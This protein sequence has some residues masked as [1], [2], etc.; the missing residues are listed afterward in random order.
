MIRRTLVATAV[1]VMGLLGSSLCFAKL[2]FVTFD[3]LLKESSLIVVAHSTEAR[4]E[5]GGGGHALLKIGRVVRGSSTSPTI[6]IEWPGREDDQAI[7]QVDRDYLLFLRKDGNRYAPAIHGVSYWSLSY[8]RD[9]KQVVE[10]SYPTAYVT[11]PEEMIFTVEL[12]PAWR[13]ELTSGCVVKAI[14]VEGLLKTIR[15]KRDGTG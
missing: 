5:A 4:L 13:P 2:D 7:R 14:S 15:A 8:T 3:D 11:V 12:F 10:Y 9:L 6:R 1:V